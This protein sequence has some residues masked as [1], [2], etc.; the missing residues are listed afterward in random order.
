M[1]AASPER[2]LLH[3]SCVA[4]AGG[5]VLLRGPS[6]AGKSDLALRLIAQGATLVADDYVEIENRGASL[7]ASAPAKIAGMM[8]IRGVGLVSVA[9]SPGAPLALLIDLVAPEAVPRLPEQTFEHILGQ[10]VPRF[11]L[12]PFESSAPAKIVMILHALKTGSFRT[13]VTRS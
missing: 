6:G 3:G 2:L 12:A 11:A 4:L 9:H 8:E 5:A 10:T 13:D 1:S 7:W